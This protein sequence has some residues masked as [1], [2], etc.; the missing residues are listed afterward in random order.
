V[1]SLAETAGT[2]IVGM[3]SS[4]PDTPVLLGTSGGNALRTKIEALVTRIR[5][6]KQFVSVAEGESQV[7]PSI[8]A[9]SATEVAALSGEG[10]LLVFPL[11]EV[12]E[13]PN[14]GRGVMGIKL[15]EG[16]SMLGLR[17]VMGEIRIAAF[18]RSDKR[19]TLV[20]KESD[21]AH[22]RGSR[23]RTGRKL[24]PYFKRVEGFE[25]AAPPAL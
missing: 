16:E 13:L 24:E 4:T 19:T 12:N 2:A 8:I 22:Y 17:P 21:L 6:G 23:A 18:G 9:A 11:E 3:I 14:G 25:P 5:A 20:I 7:T 1:S 10:R 15:H